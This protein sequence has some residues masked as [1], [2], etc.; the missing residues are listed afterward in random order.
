MP[1][2]K[3]GLRKLRSYKKSPGKDYWESW[4]KLSWDEAKVIASPIDS[5]KLKSLAIRTGFPFLDILERIIADIDHGASIGVAKKFQVPSENTNAPSAFDNGG[6]VSDALFKM[7][8][9][10]HVMGPFKE[11]DIPFKIVRMS[12]LMA[13]LKPT[14]EARTILNL[15]RGVPHS[16]NEGID[17]K[18]YPTSMSST[19]K[20]IRILIRCGVGAEMCKNDWA[21]AYKQIRVATDEV[22]QQGFRWMDKVF[23]ELC[24]VFGASSSPGLYDR[25]AKLVLWII[26]VKSSMPKRCIT[27]HVDDVCS[28]SPKGSNAS[29]RFFNTYREVCANI[30]VELADTADPDKAFSPSTEGMVLGVFYDTNEFVWSLREDKLSRILNMIEYGIEMEEMTQRFVKSLCGKLVDIRCLV[31][32]SKFYLSQ[33]IQDANQYTE[34]KDMEK[35]VNLTDWTRADL[36]WWKLVL[37]LF[38]RKTKLQDP[39]RR[40]EPRALRAYTDAAGGSLHGQGRGVGMVIFPNIW[41]QLTYGN[42]I[43]GGHLAYDGKLLSCKMSVWELVGPLLVLVCAPDTVRNRQVVTY[44]DNAGS[45]QMYSKGWATQCNLCN[46]VIRAIHLVAEALKCDFWVEKIKRCSSK[47]SEAA[48]AL[49]KGHRQ[50]FLI[51]MPSAARIFPKKTP[52]TLKKWIEN[53]VPD[54]KLGERIVEEMGSY[55]DVLKYLF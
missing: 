20:W 6:E 52:E 44:V 21:G 1:G 30:G 4:P 5:E 24:L 39:D 32:N 37:P 48:D 10:K 27:Q 41:A 33:L 3:F 17:K 18:D 11:S 35:K 31:P 55:T 34:S 54:R 25:L 22:W 43:N 50:R 29:T 23:F 47:E 49:S 38:N 28:A 15:S 45:V 26:V 19:L 36:S 7:L 8:K 12:G 42:L 2:P 14:G 9:K 51:N 46:S 16:L 13:K 53:P 40:P